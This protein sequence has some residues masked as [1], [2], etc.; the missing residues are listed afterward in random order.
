MNTG[1]T[2]LG[3]RRR[4]FHTVDKST[5]VRCEQSLKF[6]GLKTAKDYPD[7]MRHIKFTEKETGKH[8][9]FLTN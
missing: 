7:K 3:F 5:S 2:N 9:V 8:N 4:Y 1:K 6:T